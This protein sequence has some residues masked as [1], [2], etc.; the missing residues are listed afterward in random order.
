MED[1]RTAVK[2]N[3]GCDGEGTG[4]LTGYGTDIGM[5]SRCCPG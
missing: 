2:S 5:S 3:H 1:G 4:S